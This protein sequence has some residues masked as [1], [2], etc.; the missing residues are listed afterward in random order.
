MGERAYKI[1]LAGAAL[2]FIGLV[3]HSVY[4]IYFFVVNPASQAESTLKV[5]GAIQAA[6]RIVEGV[7]IS[8]AFFGVAR[9]LRPSRYP[10]KGPI[11]Q[12]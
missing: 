10:G 9:L 8:L 11:G 6:G 3:R 4:W 1:V 5:I 2:A 12:A 7:G